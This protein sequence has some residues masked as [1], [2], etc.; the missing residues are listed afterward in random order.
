[1]AT[2]TDGQA[3]WQQALE[4]ERKGS[5][6]E[7]EEVILAGAAHAGGAASVA[8][9]YRQRAIRLAAEG[10]AAGARQSRE[11]AREWIWYYASQATSVAEEAALA[12][13]RDRFLKSLVEE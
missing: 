2:R 3:W 12:L 9:M 7:A 1:M 5:L 11:Q 4:L 13:E 10:D 8:E 6:V